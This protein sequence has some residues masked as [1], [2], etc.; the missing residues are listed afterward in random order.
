MIQRGIPPHAGQTVVTAGVP[1]GHAQAAMIM[2]HGRNAGPENIL[3]LAPH[4]DRLGF[5]YLAPTAAGRTWYPLSFLAETSKNEPGISSGLQ[6]LEHLVNDVVAHGVAKEQI[7]LL[8]FSQ[9]A[10]LTAEFAVRNAAR[11][12]GLLVFSGGLIGP[13]GTTWTYPGSFEGMPVFLGCSDVDAHIPKQRVEESA[14]IFARMGADVTA[15]L[16]PG[17]G[18]LVN[19]DEIAFA[20]SV[21]DEVLARATSQL[22]SRRG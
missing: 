2:V 13:P 10:C 5:T 16:Y 3:D 18:H 22:Q 14:A 15:R 8:G 9:G 20:R 1:L 4:F 21:M 6:V 7:V 17:M 12:G 19:D 11:F